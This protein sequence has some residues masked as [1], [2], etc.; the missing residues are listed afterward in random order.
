MFKQSPVYHNTYIFLK[1]HLTFWSRK[2]SP[3]VTFILVNMIGGILVLGGYAIG[4]GNF[5]EHRNSLWG[6]VSTSWRQAI[7]VSMLIA[8]VG[9]LMFCYMAVFKDGATHFSHDWLLG[10]HSVTILTAIF[11]ISAACWM[12][13]LLTYII[14]GTNF[15]WIL[16]VVALWITALS[17][18]LLCLVV[19]TYNG[20]DISST[21]KIL[22]L[23]GLTAITFHCLVMDAIL[24]V[25]FFHKT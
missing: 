6:G 18:I 7:V 5:P 20:N 23:V 4:I 17:L 9:Y 25:V 2:M 13:F 3:Q 15:W 14:S 21:E 12:P 22:A 10:D 11:L 1:N 16:T 24:W 19:A 8:A